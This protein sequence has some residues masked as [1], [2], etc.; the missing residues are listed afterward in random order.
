MKVVGAAFKAATLLDADKS[1]QPTFSGNTGGGEIPGW[2]QFGELGTY[3]MNITIGHSEGS[4]SGLYTFHVGPVAELEVRDGGGNSEV[5][6]GQR[7]YTIRAVNNGPDVAPA[8]KVTLSGL[9][10]GSC[11]E[12]GYQRQRRIRQRRMCLDHRRVDSQGYLADHHRPG[13]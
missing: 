9:D 3:K 12:Q 11:T 4:A 2:F 8:T 13:Q 10:A 7:A 5:P 6:A 1:T